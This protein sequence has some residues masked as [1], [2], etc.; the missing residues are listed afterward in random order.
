MI[1]DV[2]ISADSRLATAASMRTFMRLPVAQ[3]SSI[4]LMDVL[5]YSLDERSP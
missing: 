5:G 2:A 1:A 4:I 3:C